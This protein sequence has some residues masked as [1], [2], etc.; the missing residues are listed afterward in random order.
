MKLNILCSQHPL[1][2][3]LSFEEAI[4]RLAQQTGVIFKYFWLLCKSYGKDEERD[5]KGVGEILK[6]EDKKWKG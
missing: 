5:S 4:Q 1:F 6:V 3:N 2:E